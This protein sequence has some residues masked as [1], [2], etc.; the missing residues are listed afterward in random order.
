[1]RRHA[2]ALAAGV[3]AAG[4]LA[5]C[6]ALSGTVDDHGRTY[7]ETTEAEVDANL[8]PLAAE[9]S[10]ELFN[11]RVPER[12]GRRAA[13]GEPA[14]ACEAERWQSLLGVRG[15]N[16]DRDALP[17]VYRVIP[18]GAMVTQDYLPN[19]LNVYLD[20]NDV[21]YRVICG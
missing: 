8:E 19:R 20:Q 14:S 18:F 3:L 11:E 1:M 13:G 7:R 2:T 17:E 6:A 9:A 4:A 10:I 21:V 12:G 5:G 16:V 15:E